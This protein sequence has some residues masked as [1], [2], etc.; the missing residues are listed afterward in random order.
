MEI[1]AISLTDVWFSYDTTTLEEVNLTINPLDSVCIVG[2]NGG[3]K[4]TLIKL[5]LGLLEPDQGTVRVFGK[6][7]QEALLHLGYVPQYSHYDP[8]F[9][10][11]VIDVVLMGR[12]GRQLGG[13]FTK[14]DRQAAMQALDEVHLAD[15]AHRN[16]SDISG[17]QRQRVLIARALATAADI[18]IL[19]EPT[20]HVDIIAESDFHKILE[21]LNRRMTVLLITHDVG[22]VDPM[23]KNVVCVNKKVVSHP[24]ANL[25]GEMIQDLY[26]GDIRLIRHNHACK[27]EEHEC[28]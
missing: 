17:G 12:L 2:P 14:K 8:Q 7:P 6:P 22:F 26:G 1:P 18:L 9:P 21:K 27:G 13:P 15:I 16:F 10:V 28:H 23:F 5:I 25:T 19:D 24:T 20:A 11:T 4:T 3:G